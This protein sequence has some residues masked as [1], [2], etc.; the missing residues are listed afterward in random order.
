MDMDNEHD[1]TMDMDKH[2]KHG[3]GL[4]HYVLHRQ[5]DFFNHNFQQPDFYNHHFHYTFINTH[6]TDAMVATSN[7]QHDKHESRASRGPPPRLVAEKLAGSHTDHK[8]DND[9]HVFE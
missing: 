9:T 8:H 2:D 6:H 1:F 5:H 3:H 4:T 7:E